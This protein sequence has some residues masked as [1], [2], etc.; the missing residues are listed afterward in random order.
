[1]T[2]RW[3][4]LGKAKLASSGLNT[5]LAKKLGMYELA[6]ARQLHESLKALPALVLPYAGLDGAAQQASKHLPDFFRVRYLA[7]GQDFASL[8]TDDTQRYA[9]PPRTG[10]CAYFPTLIDWSIVATDTREDIFVTEGELKAA[11]GCVSGFN[12]L[13]L[14]GVWN[15]RMAQEGHFFLPALEEIKWAR[16]NVYIV[17]DSDYVEKPAVCAAINRLGEELQERGALVNVIMLPEVLADA[18]TG[19]DDY[20][21]HNTPEDFETLADTSQ[22]I[23]LSRALWRMNNEILYVEDPGLV[24]VNETGQKMSA[25]QFKEH[26]RW[27]GDNTAEMSIGKEGNVVIKKVPAAPIWIRWPMRKAAKRVTYS[28]GQSRITEDN[29]FNQWEGW[30]C[31]PEKGNVRPFLKLVQHLFSNSEPEAMEWFLDWLAYPI[32]NPGTKM[33]SSVVVHG[34]EQ[35]TGKSLIGYTMGR[36]YGRKNFKEITDEDLEGGYTAWAENKQFIMGDDIS[37]KDNRQHSN[38]LKRLITQRMMTINVKYIPQYDV[39]DCINYYFTSNH[40]DAFFLED[41]DRRYL[42]IEVSAEP[43]SEDFYRE[44]DKWLWGS[45]PKALFHWFQQRRVTKGF[46]PAARAFRTQ[47][48]ERMI[49]AG[50]GELSSWVDDLISAPAQFLTTGKLVHQRDLFTATELLSFFK[51]SYP[52][53][54]A[55]SVGLGRLLS[56][57]GVPQVGG[58]MVVRNPK[59]E[60]GR[61]YA[62]RNPAAWRKCKDRKKIEK[63]LGKAPAKPA[64]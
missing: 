23:T 18:K 25:S 37:G 7:K 42:V 16:R 53:A 24:V 48:K 63:E 13:G 32:K 11:A 4:E 40:A 31:E 27:A 20:F 55:S 28:P 59:G 14:G 36:I 60:Q 35:G 41:K 44:Y 61:Y 50:K 15:F 8:A 57:A 64:T 1:M 47:A 49:R 3:T 19:L 56:N 46:N 9:Q 26:S 2:P 38:K 58:G 33:F 43:L 12:T 17:F 29:E 62:L 5:D 6:S 52:D 54:K 30:G 22:P 39:P 45:G 10:V 34:N 51:S 21:M